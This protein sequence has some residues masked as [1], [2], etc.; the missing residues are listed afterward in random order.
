MKGIDKEESITEEIPEI[1]SLRALEKAMKKILQKSVS[2]R[3]K[4]DSDPNKSQD[5]YICYGKGPDSYIKNRRQAVVRRK[6]R[7]YQRN[8][9]R[10]SRIDSKL[11][12]EEVEDKEPEISEAELNKLPMAQRVLLKNKAKAKAKQKANNSV[13]ILKSGGKNVT[14][15][16]SSGAAAK[17]KG[18]NQKAKAKAGGKNLKNSKGN[19]NQKQLDNYSD[20]DEDSDDDQKYRPTSVKSLTAVQSSSCPK[21]I[22]DV[23]PI[24]N[25]IS[26]NGG[27]IAFPNGS[28][29]LGNRFLIGMRGLGVGGMKRMVKHL[30]AKFQESSKKNTGNHNSDDL[31]TAVKE[32]LKK[33]MC[34]QDEIAVKMEKSFNE[35]NQVLDFQTSD[36]ENL[37]DK[38][39]NSLMDKKNTSSSSKMRS[40]KAKAKSNISMKKQAAASGK[41][42]DRGGILKTNK[43]SIENQ[44]DSDNSES[45]TQPKSTFVKTNTILP[46][47]DFNKAKPVKLPKR[48]QDKL[49]DMHLRAL[50]K[51]VPQTLGLNLEKNELPIPSICIPFFGTAFG[52]RGMRIGELLVHYIVE[53]LEQTIWSSLDHTVRRQEYIYNHSLVNPGKGR[54]PMHT[55]SP[56]GLSEE[57]TNAIVGLSHYGPYT[58]HSSLN[59]NDLNYP[60]ST[61]SR[62]TRLIS[63]NNVINPNRKTFQLYVPAT[64]KALPFWMKMSGI[65]VRP[66][67]DIPR[68][69]LIIAERWGKA[70]AQANASLVNQCERLPSGQVLLTSTAIN[71]INAASMAASGHLNAQAAGLRS[72]GSR[73]TRAAAAQHGN[74]TMRNSLIV[75]ASTCETMWCFTTDSTTLLQMDYSDL[76]SRKRV[77]AI[78]SARQLVAQMTGGG[79]VTGFRSIKKEAD[80]M[81]VI[82]KFFIMSSPKEIRDSQVAG[83]T[84]LHEAVQRLDLKNQGIGG[85]G[86]GLTTN[87]GPHMQVKEAGAGVTQQQQNQNNTTIA[88]STSS[89]GPGAQNE[90][91]IQAAKSSG[92]NGTTNQN[93]QN[94][95]PSSFL[96]NQNPHHSGNSQQQLIPFTPDIKN[97][98]KLP[99]HTMTSG[100]VEALLLTFGLLRRG[101]LP[102]I[103]CTEQEWKQSCMFFACNTDRAAVLSLLL[104]YGGRAR[105]A[106]A[107]GQT[108]LYYAAKHNSL[109]C[110][111]VLLSSGNVALGHKDKMGRTVLAWAEKDGSGVVQNNAMTRFLT[112]AKQ[113]LANTGGGIGGA[114]KKM[115]GTEYWNSGGIFGAKKKKAAENNYYVGKKKNGI[116]T[117]SEKKEDG[118]E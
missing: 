15:T 40:A 84:L 45:D 89:S 7:I 34:A 21:H 47:P 74:S 39:G 91:A 17:N 2:A 1:T 42:S 94:R 118:S 8:F 101:A 20:S 64:K 56:S 76:L 117:C 66:H 112:A 24:K 25:R 82:S 108:A 73:R 109:Q 87:S 26:T 51:N 93:N 59:D 97:P 98:L 3:A 53:T 55:P 9:I 114:K 77:P 32:Y 12:E 57:K 46:P 41:K 86:P 113:M 49:D 28:K 90:F 111:K 103:N 14:T 38:D 104:D 80:L 58:G 22:I 110:A 50:L 54:L 29:I 27:D 102:N 115:T 19:Q 13:T 79:P 116:R 48:E 62:N 18:K 75:P 72:R 61:T 100:E 63:E 31:D 67:Q 11:E 16:K 6:M 105:V 92:T 5:I 78:P 36:V 4:S 95:R 43:N 71:S 88:P 35:K 65:E 60:N 69:Q 107:N 23:F 68:M 96:G 52:L 85:S 30:K 70:A 99:R 81:S 10:S 44:V 106:D 37:L 83:W 33:K